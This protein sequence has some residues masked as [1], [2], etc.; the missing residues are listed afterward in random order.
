MIKRV[1]TLALAA[2]LAVPAFAQDEA[3][4][5]VVEKFKTMYPKTTFKEIRKSQKR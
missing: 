4:A 5:S 2:A 1:L 3:P